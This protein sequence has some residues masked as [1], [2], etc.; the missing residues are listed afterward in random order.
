V[1][2]FSLDDV[3]LG[4]RVLRELPS[5]LRH[6]L[7]L[8]G[9]RAALRAQLAHREA[10]FLTHVRR[11]IFGNA[12]SPYLP[13]LA[14]AGCTYGDLEHAVHRDGVEGALRAIF[15]EGVYLTV[16]EFKGRQ[17]VRRGTTEVQANP[18]RLRNGDSVRH[19]PLR[20]SGS[21]SNRTPVALDLAFIRECAGAVLLWLH[22]RRA[23]DSVTAHWQV[24]GSGSMAR[25]LEYA[26]FSPPA[27][28]FSPLDPTAGALPPLHKW[29]GA[30]LRWGSHQAGVPLPRVEYVP[31]DDPVPIVEWLAA[32][33]RAGRIP[34]LHTWASSAVRLVQAAAAGGVDIAGTQFTVAGE[35]ITEAKV[36]ILHGA[37]AE[38]WPRY[39]SVEVSG[40]GYGCAAPARCDDL[41][42]LH[43]GLA[44]IQPGAGQTVGGLPADALLVSSLRPA[45]PIVL[46]N[47]SL[48]DQATVES[49]AC[50]CPL[51]A[52]GWRTHLHT[53]RSYEKLT[54]GGMTFLDA[55]VIRILEGVLPSRFGGAPIDYQLVEDEAADGEP[56]LRL[57]VRPELGPIDPGAL[58]AAFLDGLAEESPGA[59]L[60]AAQWRASGILRVDRRAPLTTPS[61]K[62]LHL[63]AAP[64][65]R[66]GGP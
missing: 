45:A 41:H 12:A 20:T 34:H 16:S 1:T 51:D 63:V 31:F 53:V 9:A 29:S 54:A 42:L 23:V 22:A 8:D 3:L 56:R 21:R 47:V 2:G 17:P 30:A 65:T 6:P 11:G 57:L 66:N 28:W 35:P 36:A 10:A 26:A 60:M 19:V 58:T 14:R 32:V 52:L 38:A 62:I 5:F 4:I 61:G 18:L 7:T 25:L 27:R 44:V 50:G 15:R 13:L 37:G 24:P 49:R 46:L 48:G 33:R 59:R 40:I 64:P 43:D 55:D 39:G